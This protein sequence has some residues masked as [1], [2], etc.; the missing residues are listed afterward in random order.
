MISEMAIY[1]NVV[2]LPFANAKQLGET[3]GIFI[4]K[5]KEREMTP[6]RLTN[7]LIKS[8]I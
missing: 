5:D 4:S 1:G 2:W 8:C 7:Y 6:C 3:L